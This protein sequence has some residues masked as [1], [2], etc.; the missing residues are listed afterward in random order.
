MKHVMSMHGFV[1]STCFS[2]LL[3]FCIRF[4]VL[5]WQFEILQNNAN[6]FSFS[7]SELW[8]YRVCIAT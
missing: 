8:R 4:F 2:D 7:S 1:S 3:F 6:A 5:I